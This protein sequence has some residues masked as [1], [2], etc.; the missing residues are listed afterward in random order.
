MNQRLLPP[1][2]SVRRAGYSDLEVLG[3]KVRSSWV[4]RLALTHR[5]GVA[6]SRTPT[7]CFRSRLP[8][9]YFQ[10]SSFI[11]DYYLAA[12]TSDESFKLQ[13]NYYEP[14]GDW[15]EPAFKDYPTLL[16]VDNTQRS[17]EIRALIFAIISGVALLRHE[18]L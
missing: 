2:W 11:G 3:V 12:G 17:E 9:A 1:V 7:K 16:Y 15:M 5:L 18:L 6:C 4:W 8:S 14:E 13:S 10:G